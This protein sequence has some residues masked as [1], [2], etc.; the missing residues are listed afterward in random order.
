MFLQVVHNDDTILNDTKG[1]SIYRKAIASAH[2][3]NIDWRSDL[4][5]KDMFCHHI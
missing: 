3:R 5:G 4:D 2:V 1:F